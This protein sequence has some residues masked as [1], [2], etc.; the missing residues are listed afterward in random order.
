M[1]W[2]FM[3]VWSEFKRM[4]HFVFCDKIRTKIHVSVSSMLAERKNEIQKAR[5]ESSLSLFVFLSSFTL[6]LYC[7]SYSC[8]SPYR[9]TEA[10]VGLR[11]FSLHL[12]PPSP[13]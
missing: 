13:K 1:L 11:S 4:E 12:Y 5:E 3:L 6:L 9:Y 7:R 10:R 8:L 2:L